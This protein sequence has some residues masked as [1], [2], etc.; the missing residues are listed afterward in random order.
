MTDEKFEKEIKT[1]KKFYEVYCT[2]KHDYYNKKKVILSYKEKIFEINLD[3]CNSCLDSITYSFEKL[4]NCPHEIKPR[5]RKCPNPCYEKVR[6]KNI[7]KVMK[8]SA[9]KLGL[10]KIREKVKSFFS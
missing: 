3:L 10:S 4:R 1:L 5:C 6:W 2:D 8:Y 9:I 7:A